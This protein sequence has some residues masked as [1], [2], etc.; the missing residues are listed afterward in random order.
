MVKTICQIQHTR[1]NRSR[2][3]WRKDEKA[4]YKLMNNV[5]YRKTMENLRNRINVRL[6]NSEKDYLKQTSSPSYI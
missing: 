3:K 1:K 6:V 4:L 2:R 5:V